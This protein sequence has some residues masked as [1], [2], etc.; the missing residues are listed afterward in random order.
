MDQKYLEELRWAIEGEIYGRTL[1]STAARLSQDSDVA[2]K[3]YALGLL[4]T[5][6]LK[7]IKPL[8][9]KYGIELN[10]SESVRRGE[11]NGRKLA[12]RIWAESMCRFHAAVGEDID[13]MEKLLAIAP[14]ED[15]EV[16]Q[17][18]VRH[19]VALGNFIR[20]ELQGGEDSLGEVVKM[21]PQP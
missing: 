5:E 1:F 6:T 14:N 4:E 16:L 18:L 8:A 3:C 7:Q 2:E 12:E 19:E 17:F 13:R 9:E 21:V 11:V 10:E 15:K 20:L